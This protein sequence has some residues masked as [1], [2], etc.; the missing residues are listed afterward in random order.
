[1]GGRAKVDEIEFRVFPDVNAEALALR[2]GDLDL[3]ANALPAPIAQTLK[4]QPGITVAQAPSL[5][6]SHV[7]YNMKRAPLD[8]VAVRKAL[9]H[10]VDYE[11]IRAIAM[12]GLA[13][14]TN[15]SV[16]SP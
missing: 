6:W 9:A 16:I 5:G 15:S 14:S 2:A 8:N 3:I 4:G 13:N 10:S 1:E 7:L 12:Q 11:A